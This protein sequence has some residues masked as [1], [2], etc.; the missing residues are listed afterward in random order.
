MKIISISDT[1]GQHHGLRLPEGDV[2][3]H[4][5][6]ISPKGQLAQITAFVHW[7]SQLPFTHKI[8]IGGNHDFLLEEDRS[9]F[10]SLFASS[11]CIYLNDSGVEIEGLKIW[12]SP[13]TPWFH[14]WAFNRH[15]GEPIRQHW[16]LIPADTDILVTHGP[17]FGILD[18]TVMDQ[19]VGCADL[20]QT[21][22]QVKPRY[23]IFGH[24][25]EGYGQM[26]GEGTTFI[27]ASVMDERYRRVNEP[28]VWE[29]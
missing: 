27:N 14:N 18:R 7:F 3:I 19:N 23:H 11:G 4:A 12:G 24:I 13:I 17:P 15:R 5:G 2:I 25:H 1:H 8:F 9:L 26:E 16:N 29:M 6:D 20:L 22:Q 21:V 28:V 10:D